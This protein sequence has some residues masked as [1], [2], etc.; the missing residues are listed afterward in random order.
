[1]P[2]VALSHRRPQ[3]SRAAIDDQFR[4]C[5][6]RAHVA[7]DSQQHLQ[8]AQLEYSQR[9]GNPSFQPGLWCESDVPEADKRI[10]QAP[11]GRD[12]EALH[13]STAK[14]GRSVYRQ[15]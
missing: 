9:R 3:V 11:Q 8:E 13:A 4:P 12:M 6:R 5:D 7:I 15:C 14:N 1:V 10:H 2:A